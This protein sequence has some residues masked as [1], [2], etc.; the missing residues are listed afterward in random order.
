MTISEWIVDK[1][2]ASSITEDVYPDKID[3]DLNGIV[4][5][6]LSFNDRNRNIRQNVY[7]IIGYKNTKSDIET[8]NEKIYDLFDNTFSSLSYYND[9]L[10]IIDVNIV[11]NIESLYDDDNKK[12]YCVVDISITFTKE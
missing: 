8:L 11:N 9:G 5:K 3:V 4:Y 1:F 10:Q 7:S 2:E 12:Y 6:F